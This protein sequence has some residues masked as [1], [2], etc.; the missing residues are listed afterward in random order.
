MCVK[1]P[2][3]CTPEL[4]SPSATPKSDMHTGQ[5]HNQELLSSFSISPAPCP[6][7][8]I[9]SPFDDVSQELPQTFSSSPNLAISP[10][11]ESN[12]M[13]TV[14]GLKMYVQDLFQQTDQQHYSHERDLREINGR[15]NPPEVCVCVCV[16]VSSMFEVHKSVAK[17]FRK[18]EKS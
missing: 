8:G 11:P 2:A 12:D 14:D 5:Y 18:R 17:P 13:V 16:C 15:R 6:P 1:F 4:P 3:L 10:L 7:F 9:P